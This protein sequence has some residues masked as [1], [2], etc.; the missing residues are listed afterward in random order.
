M[1]LPDII[2]YEHLDLV[3]DLI[4]RRRAIS[5]GL[6]KSASSRNDGVLGRLQTRAEREESL[7]RQEFNHK[8]A[9][10]APALDRKGPQYPHVYRTHEAGN[11]LSA[12]G[13]KYALPPNTVH[14]DDNLCEEYEIP[15]VPVGTV[16]TGQKLVA[17]SELDGLCQRTFKGYSSLN[18]MQSLVFPVAYK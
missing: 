15:A 17:I 10:L 2:G 14:H 8:H 13:R 3:A 4:S 16:G 11:K 1:L 12:Y 7:R 5:Q 6:I 18:R 9:S